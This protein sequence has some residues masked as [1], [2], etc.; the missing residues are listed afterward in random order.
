MTDVLRVATWNIKHAA[1]A[2]GYVGNPR[3]FRKACEE[4]NEW[5]IDILG[6]QEVDRH[7]WRSGFS[8]LARV[9]IQTT[10]MEPYFG[11]AM[12]TN[13]GAAINPRG[14]YGNLLLVKG[15][16]KEP[17]DTRLDGDYKRWKIGNKRHE[18]FREPRNAIVADVLVAGTDLS[19]AVTHVGG[20][21]K[22][23][24]IGTVVGELL[25]R[26]G[27]YVFMGDL[28]TDYATVKK[29]L[30]PEGLELAGAMPTCPMPKPNRYIDHIAV[31]GLQV[32]RAYTL[33]FSISDHVALVAEI[34]LPS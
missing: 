20:R 22:K 32:D 18:T 19:V 31:K 27:P 9:A 30:T 13:L 26:Q 28:N 17:S 21:T 24:Q 4:L 1:F 5:G 2:D 15:E 3:L 6:L 23:D 34:P 12:G 7:V 8:D 29:W 14:E 16:V 10:A 25:R 11:K 33:P